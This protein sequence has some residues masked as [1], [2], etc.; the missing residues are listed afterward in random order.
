MSFNQF[1]FLQLGPQ[2]PKMQRQVHAVVSTLWIEV[3]QPP[4]N[5][6]TSG[7]CKSASDITEIWMDMTECV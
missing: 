4:R 2:F 6:D 7:P 3:S 1:R 5:T